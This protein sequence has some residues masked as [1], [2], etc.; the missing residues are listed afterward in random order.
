MTQVV[1]VAFPAP[2]RRSPPATP[3]HTPEGLEGRLR[4]RVYGAAADR[5]A[6]ALEGVRAAR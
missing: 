4:E 5:M 2:R 3:S 6:A 1:F